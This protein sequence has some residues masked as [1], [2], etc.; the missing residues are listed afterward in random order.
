M[1]NKSAT[2]VS[3]SIR[4]AVLSEKISIPRMQQLILHSYNGSPMKGATML[5]TLYHL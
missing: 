3:E 4:R 1:E 2:H 5:E